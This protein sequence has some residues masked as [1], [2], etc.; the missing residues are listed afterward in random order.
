MKGNEMNHRLWRKASAS[1]PGG[2]CVEV[3]LPQWRK[4]AR[5]VNDGACVE[6]AMLPDSMIGLRNSRDPGG[7]VLKFTGPEWLAFLDGATKG[8][9]NIPEEITT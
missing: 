5:S 1:N 7:P 9:F 6:F 8:E 4:A 2:C 3:S